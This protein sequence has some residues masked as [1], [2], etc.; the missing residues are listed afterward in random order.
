MVTYKKCQKE[1]LEILV[2]MAK[3][4][5]SEAFA[6]DNDPEDFEDYMKVAFSNERLMAEFQNPNTT[7]YF[8]YLKKVRIGYFKLNTNDAQSDLKLEES[9][10]LERIYVVR[11]Y[12]GNGYG[13]MILNKAKQLMAEAGKSFLWLGV[14]ERNIKAIKFY[15]KH[16]FKKFGTH[17][18]FIGSDKQTD[19]LM[20]FDL[21]NLRTS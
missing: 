18:Y 6:A 5:F 17:P 20:R 14:W 21:I 12:Q 2:K 4:T 10:E 15:E 19:W 1:E 8:A 13:A 16:G 3:K 7:F 9:M 11:E